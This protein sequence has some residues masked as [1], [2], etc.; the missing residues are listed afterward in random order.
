MRWGIL[1]KLERITTIGMRKFKI[2]FEGL[3]SIR[4]G[5]FHF[6]IRY[7]SF[8]SIRNLLAYII[9]SWFAVKP[10]ACDR[11]GHPEFGREKPKTP[12]SVAIGGARAS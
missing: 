11:F 10:R 12:T 6:N 1:V 9:L 7:V 4:D 2:Y 3:V 5:G 8:Q